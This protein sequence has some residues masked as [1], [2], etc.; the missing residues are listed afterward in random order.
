MCAANHRETAAA[1]VIGAEQ[2]GALAVP[3]ALLP[4]TVVL[5]IELPLR[6]ARVMQRDG[7]HGVADAVPV[8]AGAREHA[9]VCRP[10]HPTA[11][12]VRRVGAAV[13]IAGAAR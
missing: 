12:V 11:G 3:V 7:R 8:V 13:R 1:P 5:V 9:A 4:V 10:R 2:L 6:T